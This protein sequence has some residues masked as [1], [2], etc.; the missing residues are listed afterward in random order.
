MNLILWIFWPLAPGAAWRDRLIMAAYA[1]LLLAGALALC[2]V[3][4]V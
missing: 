3:L 2:A 1:A 4:N